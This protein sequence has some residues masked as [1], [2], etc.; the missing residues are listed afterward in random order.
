MTR[1]FVTLLVLGL[2]SCISGAPTTLTSRQSGSTLSGSWINER[3]ATM[4]L[5]ADKNGG[6]TG[7]YNSAVGNATK[8]YNLTGRFDTLPP[9]DAGISVGWVLDWKNDL[10][11]DHAVTTW[12]GQYFDN[13]NPETILTRWLLTISSSQ[14]DVGESIL[15]G[16]DEFIRAET[17]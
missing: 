8:F 17:A 15:T 12:S 5:T 7:Q 1:S 6:L 13:D 10:L 9:S 2:S 16:R 4:I 14:A 11:N 3:G